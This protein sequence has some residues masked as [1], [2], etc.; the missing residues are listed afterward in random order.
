MFL[1]KSFSFLLVFAVS[2]VIGAFQLTTT[3]STYTIDTNGGLI[4]AVSR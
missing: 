2:E 1:F 3:A 4:F